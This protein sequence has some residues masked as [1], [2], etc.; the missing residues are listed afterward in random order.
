MAA[1]AHACKGEALVIGTQQALKQI[2]DGLTAAKVSQRLT[3]LLYAGSVHFWH[4]AAPLMRAPTWKHLLE[5]FTTLQNVV[6]ALPAHE[7]WRARLIGALGQCSGEVQTSP[8]HIVVQ[9][10]KQFCSFE[11]VQSC[12]RHVTCRGL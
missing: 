10:Q 11:L 4:I 5:P 9:A 3:L 2:L 7:A 6:S 12:V 1:A 8:W